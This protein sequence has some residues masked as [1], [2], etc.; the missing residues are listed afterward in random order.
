MRAVC[1]T[2]GLLPTLS[3]S[4][5]HAIQIADSARWVGMSMTAVRACRLSGSVCGAERA[6]TFAVAAQAAWMAASGREEGVGTAKPAASSTAPHSEPNRW[7]R[8][9]RR[10]ADDRASDQ[11]SAQIGMGLCDV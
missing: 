6:R 3:C 5:A 2:C 9:F 4:P 8:R 7:R 10:G 11:P 1:L